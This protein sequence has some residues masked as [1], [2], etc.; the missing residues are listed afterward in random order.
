M[1]LFPKHLKDDVERAMN[2]F[3][4]GGFYANLIM[5]AQDKNLIKRPSPNSFCDVILQFK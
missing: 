4:I 3:F 1:K 2:Y 5:I